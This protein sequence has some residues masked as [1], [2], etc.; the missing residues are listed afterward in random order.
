MKKTEFKIGSSVY[1]ICVWL[2]VR[3][4]EEITTPLQGP[5]QKFRSPCRSVCFLFPPSSNIFN[6]FAHP[7]LPLCLTTHLVV[8]HFSLPP[9]LVLLQVGFISA[10]LAAVRQTKHSA[11][12]SDL[13][14]VN[15][16]AQSVWGSALLLSP[17]GLA[18]WCRTL[19]ELLLHYNSASFCAF[20]IAVSIRPPVPG[21]YLSG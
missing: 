2:S 15:W 1:F 21:F 7:D 5:S 8:L 10:I 13:I 19:L 20:S 4:P 6:E 3:L 17:F 9:A 16:K 14:K 12:E 18:A 11:V